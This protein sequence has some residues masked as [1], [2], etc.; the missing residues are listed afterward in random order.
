MF[1]MVGGASFEEEEFPMPMLC[2]AFL[3]AVFLSSY[4]SR[5]QIW[6]LYALHTN[7]RS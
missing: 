7:F 6:S 2:I 4:A 3:A 5:L 1:V